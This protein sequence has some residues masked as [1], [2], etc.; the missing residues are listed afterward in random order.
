MKRTRRRYIA[1]EVSK[2]S[3]VDDSK[4]SL[5]K[6]ILNRLRERSTA[7]EHLR[8][9]FHVIEYDAARSK[10]II[11]IVPHS[12]VE[13]MKKLILSVDEISGYHVETHILGTSGTLRATRRKYMKYQKRQ[14]ERDK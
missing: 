4:S 2:T 3:P 14:P 8:A 10:G 12:A 7:E 13:E 11:R 5:I 1:F 9:K 6:A